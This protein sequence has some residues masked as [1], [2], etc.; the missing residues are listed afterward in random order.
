MLVFAAVAGAVLVAGGVG[1]AVF[2]RF[3]APPEPTEDR[4][5]GRDWLGAYTDLVVDALLERLAV[6]A[7]VVG[8][9]VL[10]AAA[11]MVRR[12]RRGDG[13]YGEWGFLVPVGVFAGLIV[14]PVLASAGHA[15]AAVAHA[16]AALP[17]SAG[18]PAVLA[19]CFLVVAGSA[20]LLPAAALPTK[21]RRP[22]PA[23]LL[24][25][26]VVGL[27]AV[28]F[29]AGLVVRAADDSRSL[30]HRTV[31][32]GAV[33]AVPGSIQGERYR[34][35]IFEEAW[36]GDV[37]IA[38]AGAGFVVVRAD[39]VTAYHGETGAELWHYRRDR[40]PE[41]I[42]VEQQSVRTLVD[43]VVLVSWQRRGWVALDAMTGAE[44]W[45]ESEFTRDRDAG[46]SSPGRERLDRELPNL[47]T[48]IDGRYDSEVADGITVYDPRTGARLWSAAADHD[49]CAASSVT[50]FVAAVA[51]VHRVTG[52]GAAAQVRLT[53]LDPRTGAEIRSQVLPAYFPLR[54]FDS[55]EIEVGRAG[56]HSLLG[57]RDS[58]YLL[59]GAEPPL[60]VPGAVALIS[61]TEHE[62]LLAM[63][64][65][66][67]EVIGAAEVR[68][69]PARYGRYSH[70]L[71]DAEV[72]GVNKEEA[73][74]GLEIWSR[75]D[76][77]PGPTLP[78]PSERRSCDASPLAA[79]GAVL[80]RCGGFLIG[81]R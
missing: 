36:E 16:R 27:V 59:R 33:P 53:T 60:P 38:V 6:V 12:V 23:G 47:L 76:L 24:L 70:V 11:V 31:Q 28:V 20:L 40:V 21:L 69:G 55:I 46:S 8:V 18:V 3:V 7:L 43:G 56:N 48:R 61:A 5:D 41:G 37:D 65:R 52:C 73:G 75:T 2:G 14:L 57:W 78:V 9:L 54:S 58:A 42:G 19:G 71:L 25:P 17:L 39:G 63:S 34:I 30:D 1:F 13:Y 45:R 35:P 4:I 29:A 77:R 44:L 68:P 26:A 74:V 62:A 81:Y 79:P 66:R 80:V 10:V 50:H 22:R 72:V 32:A 15:G 64:G 51:A 67:T 49:G